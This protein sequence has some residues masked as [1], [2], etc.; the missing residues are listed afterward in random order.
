ML[1][2]AF[3][4]VEIEAYVLEPA[5]DLLVCHFR[6]YVRSVLSCHGAETTTLASNKNLKMAD[7][8]GINPTV[9]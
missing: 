8:S 6:M 7:F 2:S 1:Q 4:A 9:G 5:C 3:V